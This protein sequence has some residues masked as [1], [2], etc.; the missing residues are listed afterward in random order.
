MDEKLI[1]K[2][3]SLEYL[4]N[5]SMTG[6]DLLQEGLQDDICDYKKLEMWLPRIIQFFE[7]D[8]KPSDADQLNQDEKDYVHF[9]NII[10]KHLRW[11]IIN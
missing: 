6:L 8:I 2:I 1:P 9:V 4:K 10:L 5:T 3:I 7:T 11:V